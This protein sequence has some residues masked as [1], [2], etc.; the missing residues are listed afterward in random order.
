LRHAR[1]PGAALNPFGKI[2]FAYKRASGPFRRE[3]VCPVYEQGCEATE[4]LFGSGVLC[5]AGRLTAFRRTRNIVRIRTKFPV[6]DH[7]KFS[8]PDAL[9]G[10]VTDLGVRQFDAGL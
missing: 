2:P 5:F 8:V 10:I 1:G 3:T 7:A 6:A 4:L 9:S